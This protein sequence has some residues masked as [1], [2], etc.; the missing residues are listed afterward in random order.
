MRKTEQV[1]P[2]IYT[3]QT[4]T[5]TV[6]VLRRKK[7]LA[8]EETVTALPTG[9]S[10]LSIH[11]LLSDCWCLTKKHNSEREAELILASALTIRVGVVVRG[12]LTAMVRVTEKNLPLSRKAEKTVQM[13]MLSLRWNAAAFNMEQ[14]CQHQPSP[15]L[16]HFPLCA[17]GTRH[18]NSEEKGQTKKLRD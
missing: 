13:T 17:N 7:D 14:I 16:Q 18:T 2:V 3:L 1:Q 12:R 8:R 5:E 15:T 11:C 4:S 9:I 6:K 10:C